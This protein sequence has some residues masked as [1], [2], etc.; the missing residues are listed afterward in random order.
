MNDENE[1]GERAD[2][3]G[4]IKDKLIRAKEK[5]AD[6]GRLLTGRPDLA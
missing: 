1:P 5:W 3:V 4:Q 2:L 6:E